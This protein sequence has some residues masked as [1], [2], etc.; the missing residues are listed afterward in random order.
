MTASHNQKTDVDVLE[1]LSE[2]V[3]KSLH[4][5][6]SLITQDAYL[7]EL[8]A[9]SL[10]LIEITMDVE[11]RFNVS[12]PEKSILDTA[13]EIFGTGVLERDGYLTE[14]GKRLMLRRVPPEDAVM[15]EGEV[16]IK[17][18][19]RY[20]MRV[21]TWVHMIESL[22]THAPEICADC[23]G[24]LQASIGLRMKCASCGKEVGL[25]S[26]EDLNRQWV[27]DYYGGE[28]LSAQH[29]AAAG[30]INQEGSHVFQE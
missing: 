28:Y 23:G 7:D 6:R 24:P 5:D 4:V 3:A 2:I 14:E 20:F 15:F 25:P 13:R 17:S 21:G 29:A 11:S 12:I 27:K 8:G 9:E 22:M 30:G 16:S 26:G 10:D 1:K 18:L 19:H